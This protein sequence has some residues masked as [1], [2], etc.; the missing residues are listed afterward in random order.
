MVN[1]AKNNLGR[2]YNFHA[3]TSLDQRSKGGIAV[4]IKKEIAHKRLT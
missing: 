1:N 2:E 4:A 3:T